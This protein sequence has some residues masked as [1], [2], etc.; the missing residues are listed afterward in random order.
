LTLLQ[1]P[2]LAVQKTKFRVILGLVPQVS[3]SV[4]GAG[5]ENVSNVQAIVGQA[6]GCTADRGPGQRGSF[7]PDGC[8]WLVPL[9]RSRTGNPHESH[10]K[11]NIEYA[12]PTT[13]FGSA[14]IQEKLS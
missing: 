10:Q 1:H 3:G 14:R 13:V 4:L 12:C 11:R 7:G 2:E 6:R 9:S 8:R 5:A